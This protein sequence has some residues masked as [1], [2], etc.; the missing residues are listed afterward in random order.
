VCCMECQHRRHTVTRGPN[1]SS[2]HITSLPAFLL[3]AFLAAQA[4][5]TRLRI[6]RHATDPA[7][8]PPVNCPLMQSKT[9]RKPFP[10]PKKTMVMILLWT[11]TT[12]LWTRPWTQRLTHLRSQMEVFEHG[13]P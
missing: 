8:S 13:S 9:Q 5:S 7:W 1:P 11:G 2:D 6:N 10:L 3:L 4:L 12:P